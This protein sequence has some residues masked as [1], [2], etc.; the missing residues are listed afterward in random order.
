MRK[1]AWLLVLLCST[2]GHSQTP[3]RLTLEVARLEATS[4]VLHWAGPNGL[5]ELSY[6]HRSWP[7]DTFVTATNLPGPTYTVVGLQHS[8]YYDFTIRLLGEPPSPA[9]GRKARPFEAKLRV[10]T[11]PLEARRVGVFNLWPTARLGTFGRDQSTPRITAWSRADEKAPGGVE[12]A[13]FVIE[14]HAGD[15][16]ISRLRPGDLS[17]EWTRELLAAQPEQPLTC[18]DADI[19]A[20]QLYVLYR[21]GGDAML[22]VWDPRTMQTLQPPVSIPG[23]VALSGYSGQLW[24]LVGGIGLDGRA[25]FGLKPQNVALEGTAPVYANTPPNAAFPSLSVFTEELLVAYSD[26]TPIPDRPDYEPL[27]AVQFDGAMFHRARKLADLGRNFMPAGQQLG[28]NLY[29]VYSSDAPYLSYGGKYT[30]LML[31]TLSPRVPGVETIRYVDDTKYNF[32]ADLTAIGNVLYM[33][34]EKLE[35]LP[36]P[37]VPTISHGNFIGKIE[38]GPLPKPR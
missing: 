24:A 34:Y 16:Y 23:T 25:R 27:L 36:E 9:P 6:R 13:L 33:V 29:L 35:Q 19:Y 28:P 21:V 37:N 38:I 30:A 10:R 4:L 18:L 11:A 5:Y 31:A 14:T 3:D 17:I 12:N 26:R 15:L 7:R 8:T 32:H 1:A 20:D 2:A 22:L